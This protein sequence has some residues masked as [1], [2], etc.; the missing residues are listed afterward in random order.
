MRRRTGSPD[1]RQG[2]RPAP[3]QTRASLF[4]TPHAKGP[5]DRTQ[6]TQVG[7]AL[8]RLGIEHIAAYSPQAR[9]RSERLNRTFQDRLVNELR[10]AQIT[11]LAAANVYL[12]DRFIP[13][14][15]ATFTGAPADSASAFV[16][17]GRVD[18]D[19]ILCHQEPR[20]VGRDNTVT[21]DGCAF[22]IPPQPGRRSCVGLRVTIRRHLTGEYSIW[23]GAQ[24]LA[25]YAVVLE[26]PR[27]R[28]TA[29][30]PV[31]GDR[32]RGTPRDVA[33]P[34]PPGIRVRTTAVRPVEPSRSLKIGQSKRVE[35]STGKR[36]TQRRRQ[37]HP[38]RSAIA[39]S[40]ENGILGVDASLP[41]LS[42]AG[43]RSRPLF[44]DDGAKPSPNPFVKT[45]ENRWCLAEA[46]VRP[47]PQHVR[48]Q[49]LHHLAQAH[50]RP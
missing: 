14:Y 24:R 32:D 30:R 11:S 23:L 37:S 7:R 1:P 12:R 13:D 27:D 2:L 35:V 50:T 43:A 39:A 3:A 4:N 9:G 29:V 25:R 31:E 10:V 44:P 45:S 15:N 17:V 18:L 20:V 38:P 36:P 28:R 47:P 49:F 40:R 48:S 8:D 34:T 5:V 22:Q 42:E 21:F 46:E 19:H 33:P 26:R 16:A 41:Q 6:L